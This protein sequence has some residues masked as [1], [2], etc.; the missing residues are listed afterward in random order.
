MGIA[1]RITNLGVHLTLDD[2]ES[3]L[4]VLVAD[5]LA[6]IRSDFVPRNRR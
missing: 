3:R 6:Q 1:A 5:D 2:V 4:P